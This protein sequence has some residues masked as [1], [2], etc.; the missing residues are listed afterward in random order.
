MTAS[1]TPDR[2]D[3]MEA[4]VHRARALRPLT[5][6]LPVTVTLP[7]AD[8]ETLI[9]D[10]RRSGHAVESYLADL[11]GSHAQKLRL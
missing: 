7:L 6:T 1:D 8:A 10:A 5:N 3:T 4:K 11:L 2:I 9:A